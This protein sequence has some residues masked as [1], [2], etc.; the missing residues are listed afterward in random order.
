MACDLRATL[1]RGTFRGDDV[2]L[3]Q[4]LCASA[5]TP[6]N[7]FRASSRGEEHFSS[8][9]ALLHLQ[10]PTDW[11]HVVEIACA[12]EEKEGATRFIPSQIRYAPTLTRERCSI[13]D[14]WNWRPCYMCSSTWAP[15]TALTDFPKGTWNLSHPV[16]SRT[17]PAQLHSIFGSGSRE[18][19]AP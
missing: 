5:T 17:R 3:Q 13:I 1:C 6:S 7:Y 9:Y 4:N 8:W 16:Q 14:E 18:P 15:L 12:E 10:R 2:T 19:Q 11:C